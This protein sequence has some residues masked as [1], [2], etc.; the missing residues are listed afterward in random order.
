MMMVA[1]CLERDA[2]RGYSEHPVEGHRIQGFSALVYT[3]LKYSPRICFP[4][5]LCFQLLALRDTS[6]GEV[7][8]TLGL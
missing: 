4:H 1:A 3:A 2:H 8:W 6:W 5:G 7:G